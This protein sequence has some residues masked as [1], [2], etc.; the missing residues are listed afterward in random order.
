MGYIDGLIGDEIV[1]WLATPTSPNVLPRLRLCFENGNMLEWSPTHYREDVCQAVGRQGI[2]GVNGPLELVLQYGRQFIICDE[3]GQ[4]LTNGRFDLTNVA[5]PPARP[6]PE[7]CTIYLHIQKVGGTSINNLL[8]TRLPLSRFV[9]V[10]PKLGLSLGEFVSIPAAQKAELDLV[11]GHTYFG[12]HKF[13]G[14][15]ARYV[16]LLRQPL[17]RVRSQVF[18][19][20]LNAGPMIPIEDQSVPLHR[21]VNEGLTEEFDNLQLRMVAGLASTEVPTGKVLHDHA[22]LAIFNLS[23]AF[24]CVG[25]LEKLHVDHAHICR[26]LG[27]PPV[28]PPILNATDQVALAPFADE[29]NKIDWGAVALR[30]QPEQHMYDWVCQNLPHPNLDEPGP[31]ELPAGTD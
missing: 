15:D 23:G 22:E 14:R 3:S 1:G 25:L 7:S 9:A 11:I 21:V 4:E 24:S 2:F 16:T 19:T 29:L 20:L 8:H 31:S 27:L 13:I 10:Y 26:A 5:Q 28:S 30:H 18:H 6:R 17:Q 12:L